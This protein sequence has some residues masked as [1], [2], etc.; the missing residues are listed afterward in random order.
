MGQVSVSNAPPDSK[1]RN[2]T[3]PAA[4]PRGLP[5]R[6]TDNYARYRQRG[7]LVEVVEDA[8]AF[9]GTKAAE[10]VPRLT[11]LS[12]LFD[13]IHKEGLDGDVA[14]IGVYRGDTAIVLA[15]NARRLNRTAWL[16]DTFQGF[17]QRDLTGIDSGGDAQFTDTSLDA[18]RARVGTT[19]TRYVQGFF[20]E[21]AAQLPE[22]GR[23]CLVH[24]DCDLYAPIFSA[25]EYFYPRVVPGGYLVVHDYGSLCWDG[26]EKAVD[27]FFAGRPEGVVP[28]PD[29][30]GS[31]VIRKARDNHGQLTWLQQKQLL[32]CETW[33]PAAN[34]ALSHILEHGWS[35][36]ESWGVWGVGASHSIAMAPLMQG[37]ATSGSGDFIV[38]LD[39]HAVIG[40]NR[41]AVDVDVLVDD[42]PV[43]AWHFTSK[44]NR[45]IRSLRISRNPDLELAAPVNI[46]LRPRSVLNPRELGP[47]QTEL[48]PLGVALHRLRVSVP[49][50]P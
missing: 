9:G 33:H 47:T 22:A 39:V 40:S 5:Q 10:D 48:R 14:E 50:T 15:R 11:F 41:P 44:E 12:L 49:G 2:G 43:A 13:Q 17:D 31:V 35:T 45:A 23:Y 3:T 28:M 18:V 7:G 25:L 19:N 24:I 32:A 26:A 29:S 46:E 30:A 27:T 38:D 36:P 34:G 8:A 37:T 6:Y 1:A 42:K 4:P 16:L 20:P 21:T